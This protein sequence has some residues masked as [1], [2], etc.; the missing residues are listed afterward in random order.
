MFRYN[1]VNGISS[2]DPAFARNQANMWAANHLYD[3]LV[4]F[5]SGLKI[6]PAIAKSWEISDSGQTYTFHLRQDVRFHDSEV[7]AGGKG[8]QVTARDFVYSFYRIIDTATASPGGWIF[9]NKVADDSAFV[10]LDD[11]TFRIHLKRPFTP[12]MGILTM[13]YCS[14]VPRE[15]VARYGRDFRSHPVGAGPFQLKRWDET[16]ALV[17]ERNPHYF[18]EENGR[19]LPHLQ[20]VVIS[21]NANKGMEFLEF[22]DGQLDFVSDIDASLKDLVLTFDGNLRDKYRQDFRLVRSPYL[23]TEYL[24]FL[25]DTGMASVKKSPTKLLTIRQAINLGFDRREMLR[26]LRNNKG[27]PAEKGMIP[28][29]LPSYDD[30][31]DYGFTYRPD[32]ARQLIREAGYSG[33]NPARVSI[34]T[35]P[36]HVDICEYIQNE[37]GKTG[38]D[39]SIEVT[40][41]GL[42]HNRMVQGE[43]PFFRGSWIADYPDAESYMALFYGGYGAPPNYTRFHD[44][45]ADSLYQ[46]AVA[47]SND[48]VREVLYRQMDSTVMQQAP[49]VPLYYDEVY[50]FVQN[51]V[52]GMQ[53]NPMNLLDLRRVRKE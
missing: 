1:M 5:D 29:G 44:P 37:L 33:S 32:S 35:P 43:A 11:S 39:L 52:K 19:P 8:R 48:S 27:T 30:Q 36:T 15:A 4:Q 2:L 7:F 25:M 14:V 50:R 47:T 12:L 16:E 24:G 26:Y 41:F 9:H 53:V 46:L 40:S 22:M 49:V 6:M 17:L 45:L 31:A 42:L 34:Y 51:D 13:Q 38:I 18:E 21:F 10:A 20:E 3:G 23:N 28:N